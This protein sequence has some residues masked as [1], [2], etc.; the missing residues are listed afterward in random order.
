MCFVCVIC[1]LYIPPISFFV[2]LRANAGHGLLIHEDSKSH[3]TTHHSRWDSSQR[4]ISPSQRP[5]TNNAQHSQETDKYASGGIRTH[6]LSRRAA[7]DLRLRPLGHCDQPTRLIHLA[8]FLLI[9]YGEDDYFS[10]SCG[11]KIGFNTQYLH[12]ILL[13]DFFNVIRYSISHTCSGT[14][15]NPV[16]FAVN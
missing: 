1:M 4:M 5:L 10:R 9:I 15:H 3:T 12:N 14:F 6:R 7:V 2:A 16:I 13:S 11:N 8:L